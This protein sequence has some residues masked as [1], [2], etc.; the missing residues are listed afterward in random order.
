MASS[1]KKSDSE[2]EAAEFPRFVVLE[3]LAFPKLPPLLIEKVILNRA[4]PQ[5]V[6]KIRNRNLLMEVCKIIRGFS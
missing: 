1:N 6:K 4:T 3:S 5:T 2:N